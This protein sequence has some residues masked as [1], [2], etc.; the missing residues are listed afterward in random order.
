M[1]DTY[2]VHNY[3]WVDETF[4]LEEGAFARNFYKHQQGLYT[5]MTRILSATIG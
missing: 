1:H 5:R 2:D 4:T 3:V